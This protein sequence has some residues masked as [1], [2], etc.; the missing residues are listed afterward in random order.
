MGIHDT[1]DTGTYDDPI[2]ELVTEHLNEWCKDRYEEAED[3]CGGPYDKY[4][5]LM[6][7]LEDLKMTD[8]TVHK[9]MTKCMRAITRELAELRT[10]VQLHVEGEA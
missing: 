6:G 8:L 4:I 10:K 2:V 1:P 9:Y 3:E 5:Q 7:D